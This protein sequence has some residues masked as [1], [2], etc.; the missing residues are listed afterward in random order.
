MKPDESLIEDDEEQRDGE[1]RR[2]EQKAPTMR[3]MT[4]RRRH[5]SSR[6]QGTGPS[7]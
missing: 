6:G 2:V 7:C 1:E 3:A 4:V 5:D